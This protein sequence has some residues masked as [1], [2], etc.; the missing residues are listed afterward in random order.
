MPTVA[1]RVVGLVD[2]VVHGETG[3]LVPPKDVDALRSALTKMLT[4][5]QIRHHM[6]RAARERAVRDF[7]CRIV[8]RLVAQEYERLATSRD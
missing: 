6:G 7:D 8:N 4:A 5:P 3:L 1:T 2:A